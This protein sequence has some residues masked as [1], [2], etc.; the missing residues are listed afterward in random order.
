MQPLHTSSPSAP[1]ASGESYLT[2]IELSFPSISFRVEI[3]SSL[4]RLHGFK[5]GQASQGDGG[6][7]GR[8]GAQGALQGDTFGRSEAKER[9][10][11]Q[12]TQR[13][14]KNYLRPNR[15]NKT[16]LDEQIRASQPRPLCPRSCCCRRR[17]PSEMGQGG[18]GGG[19]AE[20]QPPSIKKTKCKRYT[21]WNV[22]LLCQSFHH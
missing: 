2:L 21:P 9:A 4:N 16:G 7:P 3:T 17:R 19:R 1:L 8:I 6:A 13:A 22:V 18:G 10:P 14:K 11:A 12:F 15:P 20:R 5:G